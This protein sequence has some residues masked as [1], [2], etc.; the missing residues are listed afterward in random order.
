LRAKRVRVICNVQGQNARRV[1]VVKRSRVGGSVQVVQGRAA[2]V[3]KSKI[4]ADVQ[5]FENSGR[6][7]IAHNV[8]DGNLQCKENAQTPIGG[9]NIVH[10]NKEDQVRE[11][12]TGRAAAAA[13]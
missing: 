9:D 10:G 13:T 2:K 12:V 1:N 5:M 8:I 3:T 11:P 6:I 4:N 7:R